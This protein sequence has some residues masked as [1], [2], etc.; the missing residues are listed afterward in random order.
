MPDPILAASATLAQL[1]LD[2][3]ATSLVTRAEHDRHHECDPRVCDDAVELAKSGHPGVRISHRAVHA[4]STIPPT[5]DRSRPVIGYEKM[6]ID[7]IKRFTAW[8]SD[9]HTPGIETTTGLLRSGTQ[10]GWHGH[11]RAPRRVVR[12]RKYY[13]TY[14]LVFRRDGISQ[15]ASRLPGI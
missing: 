10:R 15:E 1:L 4:L 12:R 8:P 5:A 14:V 6:T 9:G 13:T 2:V 7:E 11:C 3:T